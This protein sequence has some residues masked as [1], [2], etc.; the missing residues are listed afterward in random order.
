MELML[1]SLWAAVLAI[2]EQYIEDDDDFFEVGGNSITAVRLAAEAGKNGMS[3]PVTEI[4]RYPMFSDM[5][6]VAK[7][8]ESGEETDHA[9]PFKLMKSPGTEIAETLAQISNA[10]PGIDP[11]MIEDLYPCTSL[12]AGLM[13][14]SNKQQGSYISQFVYQIPTGTD[15]QSFQKA[16][17]QVVETV[18]ILRTRMVNLYNPAGCFQALVKEGIH[19]HQSVGLEDY[20]QQD[21]ATPMEFGDPL[22]RFAIISDSESKEL[23]FVWTIHHCIYDLWSLALIWQKVAAVY[24]GT[25]KEEIKP[26]KYSRFIEHVLNADKAEHERFWKSRLSNIDAKTFPPLPSKTYQPRTSASTLYSTTIAPRGA[27]GITISSVI[28]AAW[29]LTVGKHSDSEDVVFGTVL[30]GRDTPVKGVTEVLGPTVATVPMRVRL[31]YARNADEYVKEVQAHATDVI[32]FEHMGLP[33]IRKIDEDTETAC[34]FQN[35]LVIQPHNAQAHPLNWSQLDTHEVEAH[36]YGIIV[37]CT[38]GSNEQSLDIKANFDPQVISKVEVDNL[39]HHFQQAISSLNSDSTTQSLTDIELFSSHDNSN[40]AAWNMGSNSDYFD[41]CIHEIFQQTV[42]QQPDAQAV[43]SWD[44][45]LSYR[46]LDELS[47]TMARHLNNLGVGPGACVPLCF[48]KSYWSV[49]ATI[50]VLKAGAAFVPLDASHP[51]SRLCE[52]VKDVDARVVLSSP[53]FSALFAE[54]VAETVLEIDQQQFDLLWSPQD[55]P[56]PSQAKARNIAYIVYTS[57]STGKPKGAVIEHGAFLSSWTGFSKAMCMNKSSRVLQFSS[58]SFDASLA[59]TLSTVLCGGCICIPSDDEKFNSLSAAMTRMMVNWT[60]LVPSYARILDPTSIPYLK[61]IVLGGEAASKSDFT[62]WAAQGINVINAYGPTECAVISTSNMKL[63]SESDPSNIGKAT[64][65]TCWVVDKDNHNRL[66]PIGCPGELILE[67]PHLSCGYIHNETATSSAF[68]Q[69]PSWAKDRRFYKTGDLVRQKPD[70]SLSFLGRKDMQVKLR[71]Q[72][73]ELPEI[74]H[75]INLYFEG[76]VHVAVEVATV[77]SADSDTKNQHLVAFICPGEGLVASSVDTNV[78]FETWEGRHDQLIELRHYLEQALPPYMVPTVYI[79]VKYAPAMV[80]GKLDRKFFRKNLQTLSNSQLQSFALTDFEKGASS[81]QLNADSSRGS[82]QAVPITEHS[83]AMERKL[84]EL[85]AQALSIEPSHINKNDSFFKLGGDSLVAMH[86]VGLARAQGVAISVSDVFAHRQLGPL[87]KALVEQQG[88]N[89][90]F[91]AEPFSLLSPEQKSLVSSQALGFS[92]GNSKAIDVLP[93]TES[94]A[95]FLRLMMGSTCFSYSIKG[96]ICANRMRLACESLVQSHSSLRTAFVRHQGSFLQAIFESIDVP[97]NHIVTEKPLEPTCQSLCDSYILDD[98]FSGKPVIK[99]T[100]ISRSDD[101]HMFIIRLTHAQFDGYTYPLILSELARAYN[102]AEAPPAARTS[103][104]TYAYYCASRRSKSTFDFWRNYLR[105]STMTMPPGA[106]AGADLS[107]G[108]IDESAF[109]KLPAALEDITTPTLV[110]AAFALLLA[111]LVQNDDVV[112]S[113]T[114][115]TRDI[116]LPG[117]QQIIGPCV[118]KNPLRVQL[119][120][121]R[122]VLE[123][124]QTLREQYT[125]VSKHGYLDLPEIIAKSTDWPSDTKVRFSINHL[126]GDDR[127]PRPLEGGAQI[128]NSGGARRRYF[129]SQVLIRCITEDDGLQVQI[130]TTSDTMSSTQAQTFA[131]TLVNTAKMFTEHPSAALHS[132]PICTTE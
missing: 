4:F 99:F 87:A 105:G 78:L 83:T 20:L 29:A 15:V 116:D 103:F 88:A 106:D 21:K 67:G 126:G 128:S 48:E 25:D 41:A 57:G 68:I 85:W 127:K 82:Q 81:S 12:Q 10:H 58:H 93:V 101:D 73:L 114:M 119:D 40:I 117:V 91:N 8:S 39:A 80:S 70:G 32:A 51:Q 131:R 36:P 1:K 33:N 37:E 17:D 113:M 63:G 62:R 120:R 7:M 111:D 96:K 22:V 94:Q 122:S 86:L 27:S 97:F 75:Q 42:Q 69:S 115:S 74:E 124:C 108:D 92:A 61:T 56:S 18:D 24:H 89:E 72:R 76:D 79:P 109:G 100:L 66:V 3:M 90:T 121:S 28:Q 54:S 60:L 50:A 13:A 2:D 11:T 112:F 53:R 125:K 98:A 52:L 46:K 49:V 43:C 77:D 23:K 45:E 16:W 110:N 19:W 102:E 44:G 6:G 35:L 84:Q 129:Q 71:G 64:C 130:V 59:E 47:T 55:Y 65:G 34:Q 132:L 9:A 14:I 104:S 123:L 107:A 38:L 31:D 118:N 30:I 5:A 26:P 95:Y